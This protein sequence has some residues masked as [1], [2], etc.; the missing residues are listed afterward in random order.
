MVQIWFKS[1]LK[2]K[3]RAQAQFF[4]L[5]IQRYMFRDPSM[6]LCLILRTNS[7]SHLIQSIALAL[8][9]SITL[10]SRRHPISEGYRCNL[11]MSKTITIR[12][13]P[14]ASSARAPMN[15]QHCENGF[16]SRVSIIL[17]SQRTQTWYLIGVLTTRSCKIRGPVLTEFSLII[18]QNSHILMH[19]LL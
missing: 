2:V 15:L 11:C 16:L 6:I 3:V 10:L 9:D 14:G 13:H 5:T 4:R 18:T 8:M 17:L 1:H 12:M 19:N 7:I